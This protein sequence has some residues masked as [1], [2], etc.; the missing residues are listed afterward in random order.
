MVEVE[1]ALLNQRLANEAI[2][3]DKNLSSARL[4][5]LVVEPAFRR[6]HQFSS[7]ECNLLVKIGVLV[8]AHCTIQETLEWVYSRHLQL[9]LLQRFDGLLNPVYDYAVT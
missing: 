9:Q 3:V 5:S 1:Y 6:K 2:L 4:Q 7:L 8:Q